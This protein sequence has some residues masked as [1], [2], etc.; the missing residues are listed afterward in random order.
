ML[1]L[2]LVFVVSLLDFVYLVPQAL[3]TSLFCLYYGKYAQIS[4]QLAVEALVMRSG[5][6]LGANHVLAP[7]WLVSS[8]F[9]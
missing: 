1:L 9:W 8:L 2:T 5:R 4:G 6:V 3:G 7:W